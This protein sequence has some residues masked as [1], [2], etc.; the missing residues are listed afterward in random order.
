LVDAKVRHDFP[1]VKRITAYDLAAWLEDQDRPAPVL[2]DVRTRAEF[3][4]S[5]L[6]GAQPVEPNAPASS[7]TAE[8]DQPIVTYCSVGYRSGAFAEKLRAA[9]Y[10]NVVNVEGSFFRW[11]NAGRPVYHESEKVE[12][13]H[14][15][16][17]TWGL[18]L[19]KKYRADLAVVAKAGS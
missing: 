12:Q 18:L 11:A 1:A 10:T 14:P 6:K 2:L 15:F 19:R 3:G 8:K 7:V 9:G 4:V 17:R 13:V 5:H 16:N